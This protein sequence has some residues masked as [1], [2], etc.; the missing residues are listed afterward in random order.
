MSS[1]FT[2]R[3]SNSHSNSCAVYLSFLFINKSFKINPT[4]TL[5]DLRR[6]FN[7]WHTTPPILLSSSVYILFCSI[8][9]LITFSSSFTLSFTLLSFFLYLFFLALPPCYEI[10]F[11]SFSFTSSSFL[12]LSS[13]F[14]TCFSFACFPCYVIYVR[15]HMCPLHCMFHTM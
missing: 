10:Y 5:S 6:S 8:K 13:F 15:G 9:F 11:R 1:C 2:Q 4:A 14:S 3:F 7:Q 12:F